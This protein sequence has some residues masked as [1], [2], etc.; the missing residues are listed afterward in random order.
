MNQTANAYGAE[1][2]A[3][4]VLRIGASDVDRLFLKLSHQQRTNADWKQS[5]W[6]LLKA[7]RL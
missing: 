4:V 6:T 5:E 1:R 3:F 7:V 2:I